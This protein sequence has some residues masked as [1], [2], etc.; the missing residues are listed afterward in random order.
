M[1]RLIGE[2]THCTP[3][4]Q[5]PSVLHMRVPVQKGGLSRYG[6]SDFSRRLTVGALTSCAQVQY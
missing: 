5:A 2:R 6:L 3:I 1:F 4:G